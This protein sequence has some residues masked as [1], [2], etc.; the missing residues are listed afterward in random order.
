MFKAGVQ[1]E[2]SEQVTKSLGQ[3]T[4]IDDLHDT[5]V[6]RFNGQSV[7]TGSAEHLATTTEPHQE[8]FTVDDITCYRFA[9]LVP[10]KELRLSVLLKKDRV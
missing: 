9:S 8:E 6:D 4:T 1:V 2:S 3:L 7:V 10:E 5:R